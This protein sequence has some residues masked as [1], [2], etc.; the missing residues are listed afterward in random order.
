VIKMNNDKI[1]QMLKDATKPREHY[2]KF[3]LDQ[4]NNTCAKCQSYAGK[5]YLSTDPAMPQ[6]PIHPHCKCKLVA[7]QGRLPATFKGFENKRF[8]EHDDLIAAIVADFNTHK[9]EYAGCTDIQAEGIPNMTPEL[10][11]SFLIQES[12]GDPD[13]WHKDPG[14]INNP[15]D[16]NEKKEA[17]GLKEPKK[18]NSGDLKTNMIAALKYLVRK[19]FYTP[20]KTEKEHKGRFFKG[21]RF[22]VEHYNGR[23]DPTVN[24]NMYREEYADKIIKRAKNPNV[25]VAPVIRVPK[26]KQEE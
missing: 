26:K 4:R 11:K 17:L 22:A 7:I 15:G 13:A 23:T 9:M 3:E 10:F 19:G 21:W 5:I 18:R 1:M 20:P 8:Q 14:Q 25:Y 24:G 12:G 16:W 6:L 2:Y